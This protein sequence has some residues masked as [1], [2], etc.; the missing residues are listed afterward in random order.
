MSEARVLKVAALHTGYGTLPPEADPYSGRHVPAASRA[1]VEG[2]AER[3]LRLVRKAGEDG[4]DLVCTTEDFGGASAF[5]RHLDHPD[6][7]TSFAEAIPGPTS[8]KLGEI[9][10][11]Y[12]MYIAANYAEKAGPDLY[13]TTVLIGRDGRIVGMYR[14]VHVADGERWR[15]RAGSEYPVFDTDIGRIGFATCYDMIFPEH[16]RILALQGA[17]IIIH[18]TQGWGVGG[19]AQPV[20]GEAVM[21]T[22][23]GENSV[24]LVVAKCIQSGDGGKSCILDNYGNIVAEAGGDTEA[25]VT[26]TLR[27]DHDMVDEKNWDN[28]F[29][30]VSS[31]KSRQLLARRPSLYGGLTADRPPVLDRWPADRLRTNSEEVHAIYKRWREMSETER[32]SFHW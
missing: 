1:Y 24:Y 2:N 18:Q 23:A 32:K 20:V 17:D 30:G 7:Y 9:S 11:R 19:R 4:M 5:V 8:E 25:L 16:C 13:N 22:R 29:A 21:R 31:F 3:V 15:V 6:L 26:A 14:K 10:R 27:P 12:S 28:F